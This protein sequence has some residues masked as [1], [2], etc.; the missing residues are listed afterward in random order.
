LKHRTNQIFVFPREAPKQNCD[1][2]ALVCRKGSLDRPVK[3]IRLVQ[4]SDFPQTRA[5]CL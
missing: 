5:F 4:T 1:A 2:A 3:M